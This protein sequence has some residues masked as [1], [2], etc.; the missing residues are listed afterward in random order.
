MKKAALQRLEGCY[1][2]QNGACMKKKNA[3]LKIRKTR[4]L[5][6]V[7]KL[8]VMVQSTSTAFSKFTLTRGFANG[9]RKQEFHYCD[10]GDCRHGRNISEDH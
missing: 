9:C 10:D 7:N 6:R 1:F 8:C 4:V 3:C 5:K 2:K